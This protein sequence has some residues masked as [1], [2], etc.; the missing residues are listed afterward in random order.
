MYCMCVC[1][2]VCV[3]VCIIQRHNKRMFIGDNIQQVSDLKPQI[4]TECEY[5]SRVAYSHEVKEFWGH[6]EVEDIIKE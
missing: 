2:C 1:V 6:K 4:L 3:C 5:Q